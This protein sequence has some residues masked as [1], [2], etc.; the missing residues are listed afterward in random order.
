MNKQGLDINLLVNTVIAILEKR[1]HAVYKTNTD[2]LAKGLPA[3]V[4]SCYG[5]LMIVMPDLTFLHQLASSGHY[6]RLDPSVR[7]VFEALSYGV[8][9]NISVHQQLLPAL[10]VTGLA[11]LPVFLTDQLG[12][13]IQIETRR[14]V[15]Y[16]QVAEI[17]GKWLLV[18]SA[19]LV[20]P[21][22]KDLLIQRNIHLVKTE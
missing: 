9:L 21:L 7:T 22:A 12:N 10:P 8:D 14:V 15:S 2:M 11:K 17:Q 20:T 6:K 4:Y 13:A 19:T 1:Q 18:P 3:S 16:Q 5:Q